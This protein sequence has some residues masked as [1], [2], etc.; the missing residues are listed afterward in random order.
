MGAFTLDQTFIRQHDMAWQF[1]YQQDQSY[2]R[3]TVRNETQQAKKKAWNFIGPTQG[4]WDVARHSNSPDIATDHITR[5]CTLHSWTWSELVE[6]IDVIQTLGDPSSDYMKNAVN[7]AHRGWDERILEAVYAT[8]YSGEEGTTAVNWYDVGECVGVNADGTNTT[9]GAAF[10]DT[11]ETGLT[12]GKIALIGSMMDNNSVPATDRHL[13]ANTDQKWYLLSSAKTTSTDYNTVKALTNGELNSFMGFT[14]HW[15]PADRFTADTVDTGA[16]RC[17][18]YHKN[19]LLMSTAIELKTRI[20]EESKTNFA[21]RVW[22]RYMAGATRL[23]GKGIV[24]FLVK[25]APVLDASFG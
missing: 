2:L 7:A 22:A 14:F 8:A 18:A 16:Y 25:K 5:W 1:L 3:S 11:T 23:Q 6:D 24:P 19:A 20:A 9:A 17:V 12:L 15:L 10:T 4:Q 13:V 21:T